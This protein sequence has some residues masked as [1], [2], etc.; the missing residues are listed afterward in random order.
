[1]VAFKDFA[2]TNKDKYELQTGSVRFICSAD[3][4]DAMRGE[5]FFKLVAGRPMEDVSGLKADA[6]Y[7]FVNSTLYMSKE[8]MGNGKL[9]LTMWA[10]RGPVV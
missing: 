6:K 7:Q 4:I 10:V 5:G 8:D 2:K 1:M 3:D 9:R